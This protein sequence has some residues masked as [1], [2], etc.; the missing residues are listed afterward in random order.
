MKQSRGNPFKRGN[1]W[2]II[3]YVKDKDGRR[4]QK[5]KGG[6]RTKQEASKALAIIRAEIAKGVHV[7]PSKLTFA[8]YAE[9]YLEMNQ[10]RIRPNTA[11]GY[12]SMVR[13]TNP[14]FTSKSIG[15][16]TVRDI[17][18][19]DNEWRNRGMTEG[20]IVSYHKKAKAI[21]NFAVRQED[22]T[23]SP[24]RKFIVHEGG[25]KR[26]ILPPTEALLDMLSK[27]KE[28]GSWVYGIV[29]CGMML[30]LRRGEMTGLQ[31]GDFDL[32]HNI[33]HIQ[34][35]IIQDRNGNGLL[36]APLKTDSSD[37][38]IGIPEAVAD[39]VRTQR[40]YASHVFDG[41]VD[42]FYL[43][44]EGTHYRHPGSVRGAFVAFLEANNI[45]LIRLHDLR[46]AYA[47]LCLGEGVPLKIIGDMLGHSSIAVTANT[48]C[49]TTHLQ[50][51]AADAMNRLAR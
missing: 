4:K 16:I 10:H 27:A 26:H 33:V 38:V 6:Y 51:V 28:T 43:L 5:W 7:E 40:E 9:Y 14:K 11:E 3:Y 49:E 21:F 36:V 42:G 34:R 30:G 48:Y 19:I 44:G 22:L 18:S 25:T 8:E 35:Q 2:T 32:N 13:N 50:H 15:D 1:T 17:A 41:D 45:P 29:L 46:H 20:G 39:Y 12:R 47:S 31:F 37:R 23:A 24:Y